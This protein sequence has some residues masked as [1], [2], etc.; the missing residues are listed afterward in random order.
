M[1]LAAYKNKRDLEKTPEPSGEEHTGDSGRL[2]VVQ[3]HAA[4]RLHYD[5]RL[6]LDGVLKSWAVPKGPCYDPAEKRLAVHVEDH[7]V[8]Y[9]SFEGTIPKGEYGGGTVMVWDM[10]W[11]EPMGDALRDYGRGKLKFRIHGKKLKGIWTLARMGGRAGEDADNWLLIKHKDE[12]A[13]PLGQYDVTREQP[14]SVATRRDL[15]QI[16]RE[17]DDVWSSKD[18]HRDDGTISIRDEIDFTEKLRGVSGAREANIPREIHPELATP[19]NQPPKGEQWLHEIKYDGYRILCYKNGDEVRLLTRRGHLWNNRFVQVAKRAKDLPV[20]DIVLDGEVVVLRENGTTDFQALQNVLKGIERG[21]LTYFTFDCVYCKGYDLTMATLEDRKRILKTVVDRMGSSTIQYSDHIRGKGDVVLKRACELG[22]EGIISKRADSRYQ[23]R[24]SRSWTKT[25]CLKRQEFVIGGYTEPGGSRKGFGALLMGYYEGDSF[26]FAGKVGTG[27]TEETIESLTKELAKRE[28]DGPV[29][30]NPPTGRDARGVHWIRPELVGEVEFNGWTEDSVLRQPA[31]KGLR[32]DKDPKDIG[33]E[34]ETPIQ[35]IIDTGE[36]KVREKEE[37]KT[38]TPKKEHVEVAG[39]RLSNPDRIL[40][41]EQGIAKATLA[42]YYEAIHEWMLPHLRGRPLALVRCPQGHH[43]NCFFQ[44]HMDEALPGHIRTV[45]IREKQRDENYLIIDTLEGLISMVQLA[46]LEIHP[47]GSREDKIEYP[48]RMVFDLDPDPDVSWRRVEEAAL[49]MKDELEQLGLESFVKTTGGKG[50]HV[51]VPL[52]RRSDW[53]EVKAVS[54]AIAFDLA[55]RYSKDYTATMS[56]SKRKNRIYIDYV[57]NSRGATSVA[58][59][60]TRAR[61][62]APVST[63]VSWEEIERGISPQ[64]FTIDTVV[65]RLR[66]LEKDPWEGIDSINQSITVS[67]LR[68]LK[69][70]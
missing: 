63:P 46:V 68:E 26:V 48:D 24:R 28:I 59:Y 11:W 49:H 47:W 37:T 65:D 15:D 62:G 56:K 69:M 18:R 42:R 29:F 22:L 52:V 41:P 31:F 54:K 57:R 50:L 40:Y 3:K 36:G 67:L 34:S 5:F 55:H 23:Q 14:Q 53:D 33:L 20:S 10:G 27:Y 9:G 6:E 44:K 17:A 32:E 38:K 61:Y 58:A 66:A 45:P 70:K 13:R 64:A 43:R 4:T 60:S 25:K 30:E 21:R 8:E 12:H 39:I 2:Y 19:V 1:S 51:V 35:A 7:P 16:A